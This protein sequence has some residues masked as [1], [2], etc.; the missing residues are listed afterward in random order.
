MTL[1]KILVLSLKA[2]LGACLSYFA[3]PVARY[4]VRLREDAERELKRLG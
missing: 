4:G 3:T 1:L 2:W